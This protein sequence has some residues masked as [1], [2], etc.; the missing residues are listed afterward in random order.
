[1]K[2]A[3]S[4]PMAGDG[5]QDS[6]RGRDATC[7]HSAARGLI[8]RMSC[9][10]LGLACAWPAVEQAPKAAPS[11]LLF[12][13]QVNGATPVPAQTVQ[14]TVPAGASGSCPDRRGG[15]TC[16]RANGNVRNGPRS[17]GPHGKGKPYPASLREAT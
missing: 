7:L 17:P 2:T 12:S 4:D 1:M 3:N 10:G 14:V 5:L 11:A 15:H 6:E 9:C 8:Q 13:Y 16:A